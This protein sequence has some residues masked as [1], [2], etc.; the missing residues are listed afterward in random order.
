MEIVL[1]VLSNSPIVT[2]V[3]LLLSRLVLINLVV[4]NSS[5]VIL[6]RINRV[7]RT[8]KGRQ[9][10]RPF[11]QNSVRITECWSRMP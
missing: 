7:N 6:I 5:L 1:F 4:N 8:K 10:R 9:K 11:P 3:C 2:K